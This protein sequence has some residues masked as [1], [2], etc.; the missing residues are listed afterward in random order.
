MNDLI[1]KEIEGFTDQLLLTINNI[2]LQGYSVTTDSWAKTIIENTMKAV[3]ADKTAS[4][5]FLNDHP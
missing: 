1:I 4:S 3:P 2:R 5:D